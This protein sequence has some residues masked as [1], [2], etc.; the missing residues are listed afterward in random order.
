VTLQNLI[1]SINL[2]ETA[3]WPKH[4]TSITK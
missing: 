2:Q 1:T 4:A 3:G